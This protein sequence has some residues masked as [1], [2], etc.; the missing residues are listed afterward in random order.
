MIFRTYE[1]YPPNEV[2]YN[3]IFENFENNYDNIC[4]ICFEHNSLFNEVINLNAQTVY[5]KQC[6][7]NA[8][9]HNHC[10]SIWHTHTQKCPICRVEMIAQVGALNK[11]TLFIIKCVKIFLQVLYSLTVAHFVYSVYCIFIE[12]YFFPGIVV[13]RG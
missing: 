12:S 10:L 2:C 6:N 4:I 1:H 9:I 8:I 5:I 3:I 13:K 7:C 11:T